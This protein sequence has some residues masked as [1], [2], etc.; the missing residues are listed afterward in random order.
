M[1]KIVIVICT[2]FS[3]IVC[4]AQENTSFLSSFGKLNIGAEGYSFGYEFPISNKMVWE[5]TFGLGGGYRVFDRSFD[6]SFG[7][8]RP[9]TFLSSQLKYLYNRRKKLN[10]GKKM[11]NNVGNFIG[12]KTKYS[13]G[14][15][16]TYNLNPSF[17]LS[18]QWGLQ[19]PLGNKFL[20]TPHVGLGYLQDLDTSHGMLYP[21]IDFKFSFKLF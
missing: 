14:K 6:Y 21:S 2:L 7:L 10:K 15:A 11:I 4:F 3:S 18:A 5:N 9:V 12:L 13:F 17:L 8:D 16:D 1:K 20:F 19:I